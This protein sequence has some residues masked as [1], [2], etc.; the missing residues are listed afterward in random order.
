VNY[1]KGTNR[2]L[3]PVDADPLVN[4]RNTEK[5]WRVIRDGRPFDPEQ[6]KEPASRE[7]IVDR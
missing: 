4:I 3:V 6:L 7:A 1:S 2:R 5:I